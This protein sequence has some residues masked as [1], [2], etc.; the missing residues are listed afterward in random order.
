MKKNR[1]LYESE[2]NKILGLSDTGVSENSYTDY[3]RSRSIILKLIAL[4]VI[5]R[6]ELK[7]KKDDKYWLDDP[8]FILKMNDLEKIRSLIY[9]GTSHDD[10]FFEE[11]F[12]KGDI[13]PLFRPHFQFSM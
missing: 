11:R 12:G 8:A 7:S 6:V 9:Q 1:N 13:K 10:A 2:D 4:N 5:S 3:I